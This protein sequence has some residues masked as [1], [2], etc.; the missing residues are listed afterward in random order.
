MRKSNRRKTIMEKKL[1]CVLFALCAVVLPVVAQIK[2]PS[3]CSVYKPAILDRNVIKMSGLSNLTSQPYGQ[4]PVPRQKKY[5]IA[6]SDRANNRTFAEP[7][8]SA[9]QYSTLSFN[10]KV[11]IAKIQNGFALVISD[12]KQDYWPNIS[13]AATVRGWVKLTN[14]LLW[15][16]CPANEYGIYNKAVICL[17]IDASSIRD[18]SVRGRLFKNP[19]ESA[20]AKLKADMKFYYV[21]KTEGDK[22]LLAHEYTLSKGISDKM[23][24]GWVD[25]S[26][27]I[28][29]NQRSCLEPTWEPSDVDFYSSN[30][31]KAKVLNN[32][33]QV[34]IDV[35]YNI[36]RNQSSDPFR[37]RMDPY[38][39][40]FP[41]LD[42]SDQNIYHC[43]AFAN[44][45]GHYVPGVDNIS[46][47]IN[48]LNSVLL[49]RQKIN[50][51]L[52]I[53]GTKSMNDY[54]DAVQKAVVE[55]C[56]YFS[57]KKIR[58]GAVIFRDF[59]DGDKAV[60]VF[61]M[62]SP[63]NPKL[64]EF[65]STKGG[66]GAVSSPKDKDMGE[67]LYYGLNTALDAF[68]FN[69]SESN[70][71]L[72]VG[73]CGDNGRGEKFGKAV[74]EKEIID[75]MIRGKVSFM[76][77]QVRNNR[78]E[79]FQKFNSQMISIMQNVIQGRYDNDRKQAEKNKTAAI[80]VF[81]KEVAGG[82]D[83]QGS[84]NTNL[85]IGMYRNADVTKGVMPAVELSALMENS[86]NVWNQ[87]VMKLTD[88]I[89]KLMNE[90]AGGGDISSIFEE[91][92]DQTTN[93]R[94]GAQEAALIGAIGKDTYEAL[95]K[96]NSMFGVEGWTPRLDRA[97]QRPYYKSVVFIS[98]DELGEL[99]EKLNPLYK[100]ARSKSNSRVEYVEA[101]KALVKSLLPGIDEKTIQ[102]K[103]YDEIL[104][105]IS[106]LNEKPD[107]LKL[108]IKDISDPD[109]VSQAKYLSIV[110]TMARKYEA[111]TNI[112]ASAYPYSR[113][114]SG[115]KYYW[116]P[117]EQFP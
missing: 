101:V 41:L 15:D 44:A 102:E 10:E 54:F 21:M 53:D 103:G 75:K 3:S 45:S 104:Q 61:P 78:S 85:Y 100:V 80:Q 108:K 57:G 19:S 22:A 105:L 68:Q 93:P 113:M 2:M 112:Q 98:S 67:A 60:Q 66:Y 14:L 51:G 23:L 7:S 84:S 77:F 29:W 91:N 35:S 11:T 55:G 83:M 52:V 90:G 47:I 6:Y 72:V 4:Q 107:A 63:S 76:G 32:K 87:S 62:T 40:R 27:F 49:D 43:T 110:N 116:I 74:H 117:M 58:V 69:P 42:G 17:N 71:L 81:A 111:L 18:A 13:G 70:I 79:D 30:K 115:I 37:Y 99:I 89:A 8:T 33:K 86:F 114:F 56:K 36:P 12:P 5:W 59:E 24:Y 94:V 20:S 95:A 92:P 48:R 31:I 26:S 46:E 25:R 28:P 73:D 16:S 106:G 39:L 65:L 50:I 96:T 38:M 97:S 1:L 34:L 9:K 88:D 82:Y 109:A 64:E